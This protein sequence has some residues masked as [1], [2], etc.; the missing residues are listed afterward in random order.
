MQQDNLFQALG[1]FEAILAAV[2]IF[3]EKVTADPDLSG[4]FNNLD[5]DGQQQKMVS[6]M[7]WA[8]GGPHE[9]RGRDLREAHRGLVRNRGLGDSHF[10]KVAGH[11][12]ATLEELVVAP[13]L[14]GQVIALVAGT[15]DEVL[16]R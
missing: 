13:E 6:F 1:G 7:S 16:D 9:Y 14:I 5:M 3:Y 15:R 10:D 2:D 4:F 12:Q 8:F 11:L